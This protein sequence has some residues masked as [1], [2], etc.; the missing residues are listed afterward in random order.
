MTDH[1]AGMFG[2]KQPKAALERRMADLER[3]IA[4]IPSRYGAAAPPAVVR[5]RVTQ[6]AFNPSTLQV[7]GL[8]RV[9]GDW[10]PANPDGI[11]GVGS[12]DRC[13][14]YAV[15]ERIDYHSFY[16]V[17][18]G[19]ITVPGGTLTPGTKY[20]VKDGFGGGAEKNY[21]ASR[22]K[23]SPLI[24]YEALSATSALV[25][26]ALDERFPAAVTLTVAHTQ[27]SDATKEAYYRDGTTGLWT[28]ADETNY[29]DLIGIRVG[30]DADNSV[31]VLAGRFPRDPQTSVGGGTY[32]I[33]GYYLQTA[34]LA[35]ALLAAPATP[36]AGLSTA[37]PD[38][39]VLFD[40]GFGAA[41]ADGFPKRAV[42]EKIP[43]RAVWANS[44]ATADYPRPLS[45]GADGDVLQRA[46]GVLVWGAVP[47]GGG[48]GTGLTA[49]AG[50]SV[51]ANATSTSTI[52]TA[53]TATADG[54]VCLR[55]GGALGFGLIADAN[56][57]SAAGI[58]WSK[59]SKAGATAVDVGAD[60]SG[61]ASS[62][63]AAHLATGDPHTQ[64]QPRSEK[65]AAN[66]YASLDATG[67]VP[68]AQLPASGGG[69][70][71][72][73]AGDV[74]GVSSA[75]SVEKIR[76]RTVSTVAPGGDDCFLWW[77][78]TASEIQFFRFWAAVANRG[79][80]LTYDPTVSAANAR[81]TAIE[82]PTNKGTL[83][84][85]RDP[86]AG[87]PAWMRAID[88]G[89]ATTGGGT[90]T[91]YFAAGKS[92]D[93]DSSGTVT[94]Q[95]GS[96]NKMIVAAADFV[97]SGHTVRLREIDFCEAGVAKKRLLLCSEAY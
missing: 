68:S 13:E 3:G 59:I 45:A 30:L 74:T 1:R 80:V 69:G 4:R 55:A 58:A 32:G 28:P 2:D 38:R 31:L 85:Y 50:T 21:K 53:L 93:I 52:P 29:E 97:G 8:D 51:L 54:Q 88:I 5:I 61:A 39:M 24:A 10:R 77:N 86:A 95:Y 87:S 22:V 62:A 60:V 71:V 76:G 12:A 11:G 33:G 9:T 15:A 26:L 94:I 19:V 25:R 46:G 44:T 91:V 92:I 84:A 35:G 48:S 18:S 83:F 20:Y 47:G 75:T 57:A 82:G 43:A 89:D 16:A 79:A 72:T 90:L 17:F 65:G 36:G 14:V 73:L 49:I 27:F 66:G 64:Y 78:S 40:N 37:L 34:S 23:R 70:T 7:I 67:K 81:T 42:L 96:T 41:I 56:V 6:A 63:I